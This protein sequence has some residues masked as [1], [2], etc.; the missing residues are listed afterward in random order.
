MDIKLCTDYLVHILKSAINGTTPD[1]MPDGINENEFLQ[2]CAF[3]KLE[4]IVYLTIGDKLSES[5]QKNLSERYNR[6]VFVSATQQYYLEEVENALSEN[7]IDYLVLKGRELVKLYPSE[8]M[9]QSADFDIYLGRENS[10]KAKDIMLGLGFEILSY[11][12][13]D[14]H[15]EYVADKVAMCEIHPVLIQ[16]NHPWQAECNKIPERLI[17]AD[18]KSHELKMTAEDFY[19]YNLAHTAKHMKFAGI[20]IRAFL[21]MWLIYKNYSDSFNWEYLNEKLKLANLYEFEKNMRK[22]CELWFEDK[23]ADE[24]IQ[25]MALYVAKS[26]WVG[27]YE[28]E[29]STALAEAAGNTSSVQA[30]KFGKYKSMFF[31][32]LEAMTVRYPILQKHK[33]LLPFCR[34]HRAIRAIIKRRDVIRDVANDLESGNMETGKAIVALKKQ[35]GL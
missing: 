28:Q 33:W 29:K 13:T 4:N 7:K 25:A 8:D 30:A 16:N 31:A 1:N 17:R 2:F 14:E 21:D 32:P 19:L 3:H 34:I 10:K 26:G 27:T 20:G 5:A 12:D 9:R 18:E 35:I 6:S 23:D 11:T 22:L 24:T 15:D